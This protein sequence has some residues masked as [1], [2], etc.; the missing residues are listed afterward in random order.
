MPSFDG[1][2]YLVGGEGTAYGVSA[3]S[4]NRD[5]ALAFVD[6]LA[7]S[8]NLARLAH[9][10]GGVPGLEGV[11]VEPGVLS[12]SHERWAADGAYEVRPYFDRVYLPN[13]MWDTIVTTT[14]SVI[15][16]H[17]GVSDAVE[18]VERQFEALFGR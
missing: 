9:S 17:S 5:L 13:G 3:S 7:E 4:E 12:E 1:E 11:P 16:G 10:L 8:D 15:T 14:S 6:C 18:R 2:P